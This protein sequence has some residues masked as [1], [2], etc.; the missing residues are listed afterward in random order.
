MILRDDSVGESA[1]VADTRCSASGDE[2]PANR[3]FFAF[4]N[5]DS[6]AVIVN[7]DEHLIWLHVRVGGTIRDLNRL[8]GIIDA[9]YDWLF[10]HVSHNPSNTLTYPICIINCF[11]STRVLSYKGAYQTVDYSAV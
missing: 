10:R 8:T 3:R 1:L 5:P 11:L 7:D 4:P 9:E 2:F 6:V